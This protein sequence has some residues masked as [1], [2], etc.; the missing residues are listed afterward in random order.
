MNVWGLQAASILDNNKV[1][2]LSSS[3]VNGVEN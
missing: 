2:Y 1:V 3:I